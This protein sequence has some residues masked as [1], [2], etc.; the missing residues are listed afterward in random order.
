MVTIIIVTATLPVICHL[1]I[2]AAS[3]RLLDIFWQDHHCHSGLSRFRN[4]KGLLYLSGQ[5][6]PFLYHDSIFTY[7]FRQTRHIQFLKRPVSHQP[8]GHLSCETYERH[9][10]IP[11]G[12]D[13]SYQIGS[14]GSAGHKTDACFSRR[15]GI[16]VRRMDQPLLVTGQ[17]HLN[18]RLSIKRMKQIN[19][20]SAGIG[21]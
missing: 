19:D 18:V 9:T 13:A 11:G 20:L 7:I 16:P 3:I 6:L 12:S 8:C 15:A 17:Y 14:P 4:V 1:F 10:V 5:V 21:K 2:T